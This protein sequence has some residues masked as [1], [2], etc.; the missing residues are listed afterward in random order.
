MKK[1]TK[2]KSSTPTA[3]PAPQTTTVQ[4]VDAASAKIPACEASRATIVARIDVGFGN[5]LYIRGEG[6][7]LSWDRGLAMDCITDNDWTVTIS[8]AQSP[9]LFKVL[10][11]DNTWCLGPDYW[12]EPD[13]NLVVE[14]TF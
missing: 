11:N 12:L 4:S 1:I 14:P 2:K 8:G 7:G 13:G 5:S 9:I 10:L 6:P 3:A